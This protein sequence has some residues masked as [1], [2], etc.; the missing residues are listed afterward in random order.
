MKTVLLL[1]G[2]LDSTVLLAE[3]LDNGA[4]VVAVSFDYG[5]THGRRE[6]RAARYVADYYRVPHRVIGMQSVILPSALTGA[7]DI[8][9][10][11]AEQ[12][13]ATTVPG[14]NLIMLSIGAAIAASEGA[15]SVAFG[16][17]LDDRAGYLDCRPEF[18]D[19]MNRAVSLGTD[20]VRVIAPFN[21]MT[22][23]QIVKLGTELGAP[24]NESWSCYRGGQ[25]PCDKCG[26]CQSRNEAT[27]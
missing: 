11:H 14:R 6:L 12:P 9:E 23:S 7:V 21:R 2:G 16:A 3:L 15:D 20:G 4:E 18:I 17:N 26:A 24:I 5:Q 19:A 22:K 8:P 13:D 25:W 27:R 10:E 1:S